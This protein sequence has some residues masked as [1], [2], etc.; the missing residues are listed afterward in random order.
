VQN[1]ALQNTRRSLS[2]FQTKSIY[3]TFMSKSL[4]I[5]TAFSVLAMAAFTLTATPATDFDGPIV[6][7]GAA[8]HATAPA[9]DRA[10]P[11]L[12]GLIG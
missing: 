7:T 1:A 6:Q 12:F 9:F 2:A 11:A 3:R 4:A 5:S 8:A 10:I